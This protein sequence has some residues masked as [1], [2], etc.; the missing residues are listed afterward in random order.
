MKANLRKL[1]EIGS[2]HLGPDGARFPEDI[3]HMA[4]ALHKE[5]EELLALKN[6][7]FVFESALHI[8]PLG[9][10]SEGYDLGPWNS[11]D[12]WRAEY[13]DM[14]VGSLFFAEDIFGEQFCLREGRVW[15]FDPETG[16]YERVA[17]NLEGWARRILQNYE[18]ETGYP[19]A[20]A[21]QETHGRLPPRERLLP[22]MPFVLG[23]EYNVE[24]LYAQDAVKGMKSRAYLARQIRDLP[25]GAQIQ[26]EI[27]DD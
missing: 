13:G 14:A 8:F 21:W 22:K 10:A 27:T 24:N 16:E 2:H 11:N 18:Q 3:V 25:D 17:T 5:L 20:H 9:P 19:L 4:G 7:F 6:G 12:L 1:V 26:F 15:R 23:G